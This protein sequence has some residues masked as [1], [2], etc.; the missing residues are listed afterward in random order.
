MNNI[1]S[2]IFSILNKKEKWNFYG[3]T[4]LNILVSLL[5]ILSLAL[6]LFI[7]NFYTQ[8][9]S[10]Y[11][12]PFL[13]R[14]LLNKHSVNL[15]L[16]FLLFFLLK[17]FAAY[18]VHKRQYLYVY[19]VASRI[20]ETNLLNYLEGNYSDHVHTDSAV[21]IRKISQQPAEFAHYVL[22]GVQQIITETALILFATISILIYNAKLFIIIIVI[23]LPVTLLT[24]F[25]TRRKIHAVRNNIKTRSVEA[26]QYLKEALLGFVESNI[27]GKNV[28][29]TQRF[30]KSEYALNTDIAGL[31]ILQGLPP[32]LLEAFAV[33]GLFILIIANKISGSE[34]ETNLIVIGAF[35]AAAYKTIPG[36][37]RIINLSGQ[38]KAYKFTVPDLL[39]ERKVDT[40]KTNEDI[41]Q[42][43]NSIYFYNISFSYKG[44]QII[45]NFNLQVQRGEFVGISGASGKGKTTIINLLLGL[46]KEDKGKVYFNDKE[47][48]TLERQTYWKKIA[49]VKQ[50]NFL[51][52][53]TIEKNITLDDSP[54][55]ANRL[56][57]VAEI[58]GLTKFIEQFPE[59]LNKV[60]T[61]NG[62]NISGGQ[63]Q[64]IALARALYKDADVI[65]LD[66][67][68][69]EL[70]NASELSLLEHFKKLSANG[71]MIIL[72]THQQ[73]S[74][75]FCN[76]I[77][78]LND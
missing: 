16:C 32:R 39:E 61:E 46:I 50:Q 48:D 59:K 70:D 53:D 7:I 42:S 77:V 19:N 3:L 35:M 26:L 15:V 55:D 13:P 40:T 37:V 9:N 28:F 52:H 49:Y 57:E 12:I 67:P 43:I 10:N 36:L 22:S 66:E 18:L 51:I 41:I 33:F 73:K 20:S 75:S 14:W 34:N 27:Y 25:Y 17:N 4:A 60:I 1:L 63:R 56:T 65:I 45:S 64:R 72:I 8:Q 23:L 6:L 47:K 21:Y 78:N 24:W 62:R 11:T 30:A 2:N 31:Q 69:N 44:Q 76:K 58:S 68:F 71:K 29:F 38:I 54:G 74:L 5:D